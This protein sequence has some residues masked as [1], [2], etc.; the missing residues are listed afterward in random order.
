MKFWGEHGPSVLPVPTLML[1]V[2]SID[3]VISNALRVRSNSERS[4]RCILLSFAPHVVSCYHSPHRLND[5]VTENV[6]KITEPGNLPYV[7]YVNC[8]G[9]ALL[10]RTRM[11]LKALHD[12]RWLGRVVILDQAN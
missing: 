3:W 9:F 12:N 10:I 4:L 5:C 11:E 8:Y 6:L 1:L 2:D 7:G